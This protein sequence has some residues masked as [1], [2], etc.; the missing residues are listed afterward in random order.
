MHSAN[1]YTVARS[2][3]ANDGT[4]GTYSSTATIVDVIEASTAAAM[5]KRE[6]EGMVD[7]MDDGEIDFRWQYGMLLMC[8]RTVFD[9][10][11]TVRWE[12]L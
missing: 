12:N 10:L 8:R 2:G 9:V 7:M 6:R 1:G 4:Y 11:L 3:Y 5:A